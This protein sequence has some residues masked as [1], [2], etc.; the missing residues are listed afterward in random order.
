MDYQQVGCS[1]AVQ[2]ANCCGA[3]SRL[4]LFNTDVATAGATA[5]A[6]ALRRE[7]QTGKRLNVAQCRI[8]PSA[9]S[10]LRTTGSRLARL[11]TFGQRLAVPVPVARTSPGTSPACAV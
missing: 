2:L 6:N 5:L 11:D 8:G 1:T 3:W 10:L 9:M 4:S 7:P